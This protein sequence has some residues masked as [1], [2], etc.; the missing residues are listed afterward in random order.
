MSQNLVIPG[1]DNKVRFIFGGIDLTLADDLKV[2]FGSEVYTLLLNPTVVFV[3][4][5]TTLALDLNATAEVGKIFATI[6]YFDSGT[7]LGEDITS[8]ELGNSD[9]IVV[10]IG[11]QLIIEDGSIVDNANS[12]ATDDEFKTYANLRC[13][14]VPA[15]QPA[16]EALLILAIDYLFSVEKNMQGC[17]VNIDQELPYPRSGVCANRF[18]IPSNTIPKSL[19]SAQMELALQANTSEILISQSVQNVSKEK[20]GE[21]EVEYFSGG[22]W[23]TVRTDRADAYLDPLLVNGGGNNIMTRV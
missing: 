5:A 18:N 1:A 12:F 13:M 14:D 3:E 21:L 16:R 23:S 11:T 4:D 2:T 9:Q 22:A 10:A 20:L 8:Q 17:R 7:T 15:T 19:K 6:K